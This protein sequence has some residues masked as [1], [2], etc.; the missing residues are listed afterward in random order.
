[1]AESLGVSAADVVVCSTGLIG[2][3]L[4]MDKVLAGV[5]DATAVTHH[6]RS[7]QRRR[8]DHHHRHP[9]QD[10]HTPGRRLVGLGDGQGRRML[11]PS[12]ATMLVVLVTDA[13][14]DAPR[15]TRPFATPRS[16]PSTGSTPTAAS[17]P[18]TRCC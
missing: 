12:L 6:D 10:R 8:G 14:T 9:R 2:E 3:L 13:V 5:A 11:A 4:P 17:R 15:S 1:V 18:T 16:R 7:R